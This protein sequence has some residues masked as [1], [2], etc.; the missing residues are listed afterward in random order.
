MP[1]IFTRP[2][3]VLMALTTL[4][5]VC[6]PANS[7]SQG[8]TV[9]SS[10]HGLES[11]SLDTWTQTLDKGRSEGS[12]VTDLKDLIRKSL[13]SVKNEQ[14][15]FSRIRTLLQTAR[16]HSV[17]DYRDLGLILLQLR[18]ELRQ[19]LDLPLKPRQDTLFLLQ[20]MAEESL[21]V[22]SKK[23]ANF[24]TEIS[25]QDGVTSAGKTA[26]L[27][28][29]AVQTGDV[30]LSKSTGFGSSSFITLTMDHPHIYS[31]STPVYLDAQGIPFSPEA[32]IED[33]VKLR[34]MKKDYVDGSKTRMYI[35]RYHGPE[36]GVQEKV[37]AGMENLIS[38]MYQRTG[39]DPFSKAAFLYDFSM[40]PGE[41]ETRGLFCSSVAYEAYVRGGLNNSANPYDK[42]LW[43]PINKG[44]ELLLK[45]LNM[46][47]DRVPAPGDLELNKNFR[48]VGARVDITKLHQDRVEMAI[49]DAFLAEL[50]VNKDSMTR[51]AA[52]LETISAN[53]I[54]KEALKAMAA[55]GLLPKEIAD[56]A[57]FID[58]V[59]DSIN[60]KQLVFFA[61]LNEV[62]TPKLRLALLAQVSEIEKQGRL[63][64]PIELR[65]MVRAQAQAMHLEISAL[66]EKVMAVTG[67]GSCGKA[68]L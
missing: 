16:L 38:D 47:T 5:P 19:R 46:N 23:F 27:R 25:F 7:L 54:D 66:E 35:Y 42:S 61:F 4:V 43:S 9:S 67:V 3:S 22:G 52:S 1:K 64:G 12:P 68:L 57:A 28:N 17:E 26:M 8:E 48:L 40:T 32:E 13:M 56:K 10:V 60:L 37:L 34:N 18:Q 30:V 44:R 20:L 59:P 41:A 62:M 6:A 51:I 24:P 2:I 11:I 55:A 45:T 53:P 36:H 14:Q 49:V 31:H 50:E 21:Y 39:G 58:K 63:I 33:G 29:F 65:K 15:A